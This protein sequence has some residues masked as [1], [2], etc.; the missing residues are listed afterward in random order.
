MRY[1]KEFVVINEDYLY[2]RLNELR[3][4]IKSSGS[5]FK[6]EYKNSLL[7]IDFKT[8]DLSINYNF[9]IDYV[10][11]YIINNNFSGPI[12]SSTSIKLYHD[13][14]PKCISGSTS[15]LPV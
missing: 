2:A 14:A 15:Y 5:F 11:D 13:A 3:D 7:T 1:L 9:D 10:F 4:L 6:Y 8:N 12:S